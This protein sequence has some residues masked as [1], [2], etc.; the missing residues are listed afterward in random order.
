MTRVVEADLPPLINDPGKTS[1][2]VDADAWPTYDEEKARIMQ[3][4]IWE[5]FQDDRGLLQQQRESPQQKR[6]RTD[7]EE[8]EAGE[9]TYKYVFAEKPVCVDPAGWRICK[10]AHELAKKNGTAIVTGTQ[11]RRQKNYVEAI[12]LIKQGAIGTVKGMTARY[13]STG[14]WN[15]ERQEGMTDAER[16]LN[17]TQYCDE[18]VSSEHGTLR[19]WYVCLQDGGGKSPPCG[20]IMPSKSG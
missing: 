16:M 8:F 3:K 15:R 2:P 14:I 11:Y 19:A 1:V 20:T 10:E 17:V 5:S 12:D 7:R 4:R 13:C 9:A 18:W 6:R